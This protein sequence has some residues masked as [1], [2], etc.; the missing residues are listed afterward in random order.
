[1]IGLSD[2]ILC[3]VRTALACIALTPKPPAC[4]RCPA[5]GTMG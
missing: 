1:M 5:A 3:A 2:A 4:R